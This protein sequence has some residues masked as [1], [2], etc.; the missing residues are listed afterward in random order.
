M[1]SYLMA[2]AMEIKSMEGWPASIYLKIFGSLTK[3]KDEKM[4]SILSKIA[5]RYKD[6]QYNK[7]S[8][9]DWDDRVLKYVQQL[10]SMGS[11]YLEYANAIK[12]GDGEKLTRC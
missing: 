1:H 5:E 2:G 4:G 7:A 9:I 3:M 11:L 8:T 6:L 12:T 10:L